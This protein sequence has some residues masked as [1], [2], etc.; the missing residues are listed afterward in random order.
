[1]TVHDG[2]IWHRVEPSPYVGE[3]SRRRVM[4]IPIVTG[5]Y[6][7]KTADSPTPFYHKLAALTT[8]PFKTKAPAWSSPRPRL[9]PRLAALSWIRA[10]G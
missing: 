8:K 4:Y 3:R 5:A 9:W 2:R 6:Q 1:M 10:N 7:P